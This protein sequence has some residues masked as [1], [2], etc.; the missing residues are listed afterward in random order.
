MLTLLMWRST[1]IAS[2]LEGCR[3]SVGAD[4]AGND[5]SRGSL[6]SLARQINGLSKNLA[7]QLLDRER[8]TIKAAKHVEG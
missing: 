6:K 1:W 3:H 5:N 4:E 2:A 7:P 8:M